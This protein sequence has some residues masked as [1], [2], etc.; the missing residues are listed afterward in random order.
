MLRE[1]R[2]TNYAIIDSLTLEFG[3]GLNILTGETGAGKSIIIGAL[4]IALG[5]RAYT[6]TI[7]TGKAEASVQ[8]LFDIP[9]HPVLEKMGIA[10]DEGIVIRRNISSSG[11][12]RAYI[13]DSIVNVQSLAEL[14]RSLVDIHGQHEHQSLLTSENQMKLLDQFGGLEEECETVS[15]LHR[16]VQ[17]LR[18]RLDGLRTGERERAQKIDI[19]RFQAQEIENASLSPDED[20]ALEEERRILSNLSRLNELSES[21]YA[22]LYSGEGSTSETL[23]SAASTVKEV[24]SIDQEAEE[25][26][27]IIEEALPLVEEASLSLR[28]LGDKY[29]LDPARLEEVE[30]RMDL[31]TRLKR[32]Y[33]ETVEAVMAYREEALK[34]LSDIENTGEA[35][36]ELEEKLQSKEPFLR[37]AAESLSRKRKESAGRVEGAVNRVLK[38][39]ALEKSEFRIT[40]TEVP[41]SSVGMDAVE[42]LF[43]AHRGEA[44]RPL[45]RVASGGELSRVM[46]AIKSVLRAADRIPVLIFDE[47]DAGIGG[48]TAQNVADKLREI[49]SAHQVLCITHL[50]QIASLAEHHFLIEKKETSGRVRVTIRELTGDKRQEEIARMLGGDVTEKSLEHARELIERRA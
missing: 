25:A 35:A 3:P 41:L 19:L 9:S 28:K 14:G 8:A 16:D 23:T 4:G 40:V 6:D 24:V 43:T 18:R 7:K 39:L 21:S 36:E 15:S 49:S 13:N 45:H 38:G 2:V 20:K 12:G 30:S 47:V 37:Q 5:E 27:R 10:S 17:A 33:G 50:P 11:K 1:L 48:R 46:L 42:F 32:K 26:L 44:L 31:I 22:L 29:Q 34:E